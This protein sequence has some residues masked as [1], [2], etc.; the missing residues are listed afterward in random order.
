MSRMVYFNPNPAGKHIGDC[1]VRSVA[2]AL[3]KSWVDAYIGLT[4]EAFCLCDLPSANAVWGAY[5]KRNGFRRRM[6]PDTCPDCYT[7]EEFCEDHPTGTFVVA[8]D[9]HVVTVCDGQYYDTWESGH[10]TPLYYFEKNES[11][12][13]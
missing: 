5:L 11:E 2:K 3:G 10:E 8:L 1:A 4:L 9:K 12:D 7:M 13:K 6:L